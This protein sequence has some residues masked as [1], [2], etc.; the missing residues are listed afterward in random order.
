M[1]LAVAKVAVT[2]CGRHRSRCRTQNAP[3]NSRACIPINRDAVRA[4]ALENEPATIGRK[5]LRMRSRRGCWRNN[6]GGGN[7]GGRCIQ[8]AVTPIAHRQR[9]L[10]VDDGSALVHDTWHCAGLLQAATPVHTLCRSRFR[11]RQT[12]NQR[13]RQNQR[14][15]R[16]KLL[17]AGDFSAHFPKWLKYGEAELT[18]AKNA[19]MRH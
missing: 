1:L 16:F 9:R 18:R 17:E 3:C 15:H 14:S 6:G 19:A 13:Q 5:R 11:E 8:R 2:V 10:A 12:D 7:H 4:Y